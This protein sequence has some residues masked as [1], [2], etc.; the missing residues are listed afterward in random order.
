ML[1][2]G[3]KMLNINNRLSKK[4]DEICPFA[5]LE[6]CTRKTDITILIGNAVDHL[7]SALYIFLAN[8]LAP[9]FFPEHDKIVQ[10][11]LTYSV[12]ASSIVTRPIGTIIFSNIA[13][14]FTPFNSLYIAMFGVSISLI[15]MGFLPSYQQIGAFSPFLL[16]VIRSFKG[17]CASGEVAIAKFFIIEGKNPQKAFKLSYW[18]QAFTMFGGVAASLIAGFI[19]GIDSGTG[20]YNV[21]IW[22]VCFIA[23]GTCSIMIYFII[24]PQKNIW[25]FEK[26]IINKSLRFQ[27]SQIFRYK[28]LILQ[29]TLVNGVSNLTYSMAFIVINTMAP[30]VS[31]VSTNSMMAL[32]SLLLMLDMFMIPIFGKFLKTYD[33]TKIMFYACMIL[34]LSLLPLWVGLRDA[35]LPYIIF[36]RCWIVLWGVVFLCPINLW[37]QNFIAKN[38]AITNNSEIYLINGIGSA[39]ASST[40]GKLTPT[41]TL[42]LWYF[43]GSL[44][45][46]GIYMTLI[47]ASCMIVLAEK[48]YID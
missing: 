39:L 25:N 27:I 28:K 45:P 31:T 12:L 44:L 38:L 6:R 1:A 13:Q 43:T 23:L 11:I 40:I 30:L 2:K 37:S 22:R 18:Y 35:S 9:L 16:I 48:P 17:I 26:P 33:C 34:I 5:Q 8:M 7:D 19:I 4:S 32:N 3:G 24:F 21:E 20:S 46:I 10:L 15:L 29:I 14:K 42:S 47:L 36:V 41:I